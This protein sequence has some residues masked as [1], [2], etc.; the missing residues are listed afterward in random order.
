VLPLAVAAF[1]GAA[2][3]MQTWTLKLLL[4]DDARGASVGWTRFI[5]GRTGEFGRIAAGEDPSTDIRQFLK[6]IEGTTRIFRYTIYSVD[7]LPRYTYDR[8]ADDR[9]NAAPR[10][11]PVAR[12]V[13]TSGT[14]VVTT[15]KRG[16]G[17]PAPVPYYAYSYVPVFNGEGNVEAVVKVF[18]DQTAKQAEFASISMIGIAAIAILIALA[19][20]IPSIAWYRGEREKHSSKERLRY[21]A[22][23]DAL[24]NLPNRTH[25]CEELDRILING[26]SQTRLAVLKI[27]IDHFSD[28][29]GWLGLSAGDKVIQI[30]AERLRAVVDPED[31]GNIVA[32]VA[33]DEFA[34]VHRAGDSRASAIILAERISRSIARPFALKNRAVRLSASVGIALAPSDG[35]DADQLMKSARLA[36]ARA[37]SQGIGR[38]QFFTPNLDSEM[39]A[40]RTIEQAVTNAFAHGGFAVHYQPICSVKGGAPVGFEALARL[41]LPNG[42]TIQPGVFVPA[43][44]RM[45]MINQLG[46]WMLTEAC[47]AAASWPPDMVVSVNLSALQFAAPGVADVVATALIGSGLAPHRLHLEI[48]ESA[49]LGDRETVMAE[50]TR[51]KKLGTRIVMDDFGTGYSSLSYLWRFPFDKIKIDGS[52]MTALEGPGAPAE[53]VMGAITALG[54]SLGMTV[55]IEGVETQ[56]QAASALRIGCDEVQGFHFGRPIPA[57]ELP[58]LILGGFRRSITAAEVP[59]SSADSAAL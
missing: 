20:G 56:L 40:R 47:T 21:L 1:V 33:G 32:R 19:F 15:A 44:E 22:Q 59:D 26:G 5:S 7:G 43:I 8:I 52:F 24:S 45:G 18:L 3:A 11:D 37:K 10:P 51:L 23:H 6:W 41:P 14:P 28:L 35:D 2:I 30:V 16:D 34:V 39:E 27:D 48:T 13:S 46:A 17:D 55:C 49:L 12:A 4:T 58:A 25:L 36:L 38:I 9:L 42:A 53:Q 50:L 31:T 54:H 29:N 57:I